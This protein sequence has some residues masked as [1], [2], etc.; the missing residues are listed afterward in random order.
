MAM[1]AEAKEYVS[2]KRRG[3]RGMEARMPHL[4]WLAGVED[5]EE[6]EEGL[7]ER[8]IAVVDEEWGRSKRC[9]VALSE[10]T[11]RRVLEGEM[12]RE[13]MAAGSTP[14]RNSE[15]RAQLMVEKRRISVPCTQENQDLV[16][17][18]VFDG[19]AYCFASSRQDLSVGTESHCFKRR[20]VRWYDAHVSGTNLHNLHLSWRSAREGH[21]LGA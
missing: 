11:A 7:E 10:V 21:D 4:V 6:A 2:E 15:M 17:D 19:G 13:R 14:R 5:E 16:L 3:R 12:A 18:T 8:A 20:A 9:R 1:G